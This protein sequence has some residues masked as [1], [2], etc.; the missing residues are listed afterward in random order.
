[1]VSAEGIESAQKRKFNNMQGYG[2]HESARK[3]V[4]NRLTDR[5]RIAEKVSPIKTQLNSVVNARD[6]IVN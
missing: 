4:V 1:M 5:K 3:A 6:R 2:W